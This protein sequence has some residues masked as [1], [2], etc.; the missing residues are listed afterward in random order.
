VIKIQLLNIV[1]NLTFKRRHCTL[2]VVISSKAK[3]LSAICEIA[4]SNLLEHNATET[5]KQQG[6]DLADYLVGCKK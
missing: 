4:V 5:E 6:L 3:E 1:N 2:F